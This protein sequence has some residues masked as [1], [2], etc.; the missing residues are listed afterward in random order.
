MKTSISIRSFSKLHFKHLLIF[1]FTAAGFV[2]GFFFPLRFS[3]ALRYDFFLPL[4][5]TFLFL[6]AVWRLPH[7]W[8]E[9][10]SAGF[11]TLLFSACLAALWRTGFHEV[12]D[13]FGLLPWFDSQGY[14]SEALRLLDGGIFSQI[15][16]RRP[17]FPGLFSTLLMLTGRNLR[18]AILILSFLA[19]IST[20]FL[21]N[22]F[23]KSEE[24]AIIPAAIT[25][26]L[27]FFYRNF[28]G[29]VL[30]ETI[31]F[32]LGVLA[33]V[34][35]WNAAVNRRLL[36]ALIGLFCLTMALSARPGAVFSLP[37]IILWIVFFL[38]PGSG[39]LAKI[40]SSCVIV[41]AGLA[42]NYGL[43]SVLAPGSSAA[44]S[45]FAQ[46]FYG[47]VN[48]GTGWRAIYAEHPEFFASGNEGLASQQIYQAA[49]V[50]FKNH[51]E[52]TIQGGMRSIQVFFSAAPNSAFNFLGGTNTS[53]EPDINNAPLEVI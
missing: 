2:A 28:N 36:L 42:I 12:Y 23:N 1:L 29:A 34:F 5:F 8:K 44:Y 19:G 21:A 53:R 13:V 41:A 26:I 37:L 32:S 27:F 17:I 18:A 6:W 10:V 47:L 51:P 35:L 3:I 52:K 11:T 40:I 31:G 33:L 49:W 24:K 25:T 46:S 45:N 39:M 15:A 7:P 38:K 48:G 30:T 22:E 20:W 14:Y 9:A 4:I 16:A 43:T 50:I